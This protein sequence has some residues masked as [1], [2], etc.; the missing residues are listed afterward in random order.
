VLWKRFF[1]I[2]V[3]AYLVL[4]IFNSGPLQPSNTEDRVI[5]FLTTVAL[6]ARGVWMIIRGLRLKAL[7]P[8]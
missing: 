6:A 1:L 8:K 4:N 5:M 3:G 2:V 7:P